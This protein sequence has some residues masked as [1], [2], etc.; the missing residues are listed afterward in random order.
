[1][2]DPLVSRTARIF[3]LWAIICRWYT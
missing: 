2:M 3:I 1:M